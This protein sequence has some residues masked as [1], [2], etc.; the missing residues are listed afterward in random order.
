MTE[1]EKRGWC[2]GGGR[3]AG[4]GGESFGAQECGRPHSQG[5]AYEEETQERRCPRRGQTPDRWRSAGGF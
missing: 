3:L 5:Q 2:A 1:A 4:G